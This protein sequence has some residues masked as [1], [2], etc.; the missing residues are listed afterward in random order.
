MLLKWLEHLVGSLK[1]F[2]LLNFMAKLKE[3]TFISR[4]Q[5][6]CYRFILEEEG[7]KED[8]DIGGKTYKEV[9]WEYDGTESILV[10]LNKKDK[11]EEILE[12]R[13]ENFPMLERFLQNV[14]QNCS[15]ES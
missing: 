1:K 15:D 9:E 2:K 13:L 12:F 4:K 10:R 8:Y 3:P 7:I 6:D 14:S 11:V 5:K